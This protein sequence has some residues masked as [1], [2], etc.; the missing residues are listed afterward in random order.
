MTRLAPLEIATGIVFGTSRRLPQPAPAGTPAEAF[1]AAVRPALLRGPTFVSF[2]G[3]R[4]SSA[5]LAVATRVARREGLDDPIPITIRAAEAPQSHES[6]WQERV[7]AHLGIRDWTRIEVRDELDAVG[8]Y[9]RRVLERHGLLWPFNA[10]FHLPMLELAAGGTLLTGVGGDELWVSSRAN[11]TGLRRRALGLAPHRVRRALLARREPID[12]PWLRPGAVRAAKLVAGGDA[13]REPRTVA[14]RMRWFRAL[15]STATGLAAL[16]LIAAD[17]GAAIAHP[18]YD[19]GLWGSVAA[20]A[21]SGGFGDREAALQAVAG[22][23]LPAEIVS[24]RTKAGFNEMFFH[25]HARAVAGSWS[26]SG[27]PEDLVDPAALRE[28]WLEAVPEAHTLTLLQAVW[29]ASASDRLEQPV[30]R[31]VE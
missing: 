16:D 10:H 2:S 13:A 29:L 7:V 25:E 31:G 23:A 5:V 18:L 24:R 27:V 8:P 26:G 11:P 19:A 15:R 12:F 4:D 17:A 21:P 14:R 20:A 6:D 3:G 1:E 28:Q 30:G 22:H 9:A